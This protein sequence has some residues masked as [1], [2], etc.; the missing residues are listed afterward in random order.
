VECAGNGNRNVSSILL[1]V[2]K[3]SININWKRQVIE[4]M[5]TTGNGSRGQLYTGKHIQGKPRGINTDDKYQQLTILIE[6][7]DIG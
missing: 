4:K 3:Q 6:Y 1:E 5:E 7:F 2:V